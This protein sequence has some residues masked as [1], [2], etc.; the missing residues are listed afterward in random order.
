MEWKK[1]TTDSEKLKQMEKEYIEAA[2]RMM[3]KAGIKD[4]DKPAE[5]ETVKEEMNTAA[6]EEIHNEN[7]GAEEIGTEEIISKAEE[8]PETEEMA[9][10]EISETV[11]YSE[12]ETEAMPE[13]KDTKNSEGENTDTSEAPE[14]QKEETEKPKGGYGVYTADEILNG[15]GLMDAERIIEEIKMKNETMKKLTEEQEKPSHQPRTCPK[16]GKVIDGCT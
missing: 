13:D 8:E 2:L 9:K 1:D 5:A 11:Y 6:S 14:E 15:E 3:K 12:N 7:E 10:E 4:A 16:C